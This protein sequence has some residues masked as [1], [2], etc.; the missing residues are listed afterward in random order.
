MRHTLFAI[1]LLDETDNAIV[2]AEADGR[3]STRRRRSPAPSQP[4]L[5]GVVTL[6]RRVRALVARTS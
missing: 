3:W 4:S 2:Q 5:A 1:R 6:A